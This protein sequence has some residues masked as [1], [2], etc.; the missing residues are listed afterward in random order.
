[1][2]AQWAPL[3]AEV[4]RHRLLLNGSDD[5][6][7]KGLRSR[8]EVLESTTPGNVWMRRQMGVMIT[9]LLAFLSMAGAYFFAS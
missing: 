4:H 5:G 3:Q 6:K 2:Q 7:G 9:A 1:M 8:V